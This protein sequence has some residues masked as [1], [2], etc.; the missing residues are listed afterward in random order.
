MPNQNSAQLLA[1]NEAAKAAGVSADTLRRWEKTGKISSIRTAGGHRRYEISEIKAAKKK[2]YVHSILPT[3]TEKFSFQKLEIAN[4]YTSL[5]TPQKRVL[6]ATF[7][8]LL[9]LICLSL[10]NKL[11]DPK[12]LLINTTRLGVKQIAGIDLPAPKKSIAYK[13]GGKGKV[14]ADTTVFNDLFFQVNIP[15]NLGSDV[16]IGGNLD[17]AGETTLTGALTLE[18][19]LNLNGGL[20]VPGTLTATTL[21]TSGGA[22]IGGDTTVNGGLILSDTNTLQIGGATATEYNAIANASDSKDESTISSD[23]DL[24]IGGDLE[25]D[26]TTY[27]TFNGKFTG[28]GSGISG[29]ASYTGWDLYVNGTKNSAVDTGEKVDFIAGTGIT[30]TGGSSTT[31][32]ALTFAADI[33]AIS[34]WSTSGTTTY[35]TTTTNELVVGGATAL[36]KVSVDGDTDE[37]QL[38]VQGNATQTSNLAVFEDSTG[39]DLVTIDGSGNVVIV[40][41]INATGAITTSGNLAVNGDNITSDGNLTINATGYTKVGDTGTPG[42][43]TADDDL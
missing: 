18:S 2:R 21:T 13:E 43:A 32:N 37:I 15:A 27:G 34:P 19:D 16:T 39:S 40:G 20:T 36:G 10:V 3:E 23:N 7:S 25:V 8:T 38:V 17:V 31:S 29:I 6:F 33:A 22:I 35:L 9:I 26:G 12:E 41:T 14:L 42:S 28:D 11:V 5:A 24:Y 4:L 30:I 1:I